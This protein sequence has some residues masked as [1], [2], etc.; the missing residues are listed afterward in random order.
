MLIIPVMYI[1]GGSVLKPAGS[2]GPA[3]K[4][5]PAGLARDWVK[6]GV[7]AI[8]INDLDTPPSGISP[9]NDVIKK[10]TSELR[11]KVA[12]EGKIR[13]PETVERYLSAGVER[14]LI[15]SI[16]YQKPAFLS[17]LCGRFPKKIATQIDVRRG[18]VNIKGWTVAANKTA[19]DYVEQFKTAGVDAIYY[20]DVFEEGVLKPEDFGRIRDFLRKAMIKTYHATDMTA[21]SDVEQLIMLESYGLKGTLVGRSLYEGKINLE[22]I[23]TLVKERSGGGLDEPT[24]TEE[25]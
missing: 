10:L 11:L 6:T 24:Y 15:D 13:S 25:G 9:N 8:H 20:S 3:V 2:A 7:E 12:V 21:P 14:V 1:R 23:I 22:A 17:E 4:T 16:A 5:D 18:K 19:L